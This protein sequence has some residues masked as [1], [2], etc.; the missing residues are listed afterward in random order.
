MHSSG[1]GD[2]FDGSDIG[3]QGWFATFQS[4][5]EVLVREGIEFGRGSAEAVQFFE[6]GTRTGGGVCRGRGGEDCGD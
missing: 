1:G 6:F 2:S 4:T 3:S 5:R